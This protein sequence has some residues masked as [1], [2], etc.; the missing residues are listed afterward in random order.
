M[1]KSAWL[2]FTYGLLLVFIRSV[3]LSIGSERKDIMLGKESFY[4]AFGL[5]ATKAAIGIIIIALTAVLIQLLI[6]GWKSGLAFMLL[7]GQIY[8]IAIAVYFYTKKTPRTTLSETFIDGQFLVL[9][10]L[11]YLAVKLF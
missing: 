4:K 11:T 1:S 8:T 3:I 5:N 6:M 10:V 9:A 2:A 7:L